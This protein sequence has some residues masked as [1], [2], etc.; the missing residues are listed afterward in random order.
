MTQQMA[1]EQFTP[2]ELPQDLAAEQALLGAL[3]VS[4][5]VY[6]KVSDKLTADMFFEPVHGRIYDAIEDCIKRGLTATPITLRAIFEGDPALAE[7]GGA[8]YLVRLMG[9]AATTIN[10]GDY[11][12]LIHDCF[13]RRQTVVTCEQ[14]I[15]EACDPRKVEQAARIL[16]DLEQKIFDLNSRTDAHRA[17]AD[18]AM[19][20]DD[21]AKII[22]AAKTNPGGAVGFSTGIKEWDRATGGLFGGDLY[23][24]GGRPGMGKSAL[25]L[26][27]A[28]NV[29]RAGRG[30]LFVSLEMPR[31]QLG[32]RLASMIGYSSSTPVPYSDARKGLFTAWQWQR[33][34]EA[35]KSAARLPL[36]IDDKPGRSLAAIKIGL[37][38]AVDKW[39]QEGIEPGLLVI[40]YLGL[41]AVADRYRG[42]KTYE[43]GEISKGLKEL[44]KEF[45]IPVLALAQLNRAVEQRESKH[46]QLS[47]LR[48]SGDIEQ[49]ADA[50]FFCYRAFYY[51]KQKEHP[52]P[53]VLADLER[54][55][56]LIIA[57]QRNGP[58]R[59]LDLFFDAPHG[60]WSDLYGG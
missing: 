20:S 59:T 3:F 9:G 57:K 28:R 27:I 29:A 60:L 33:F 7:V 12:K 41:V 47:D 5:E 2:P 26:T 6:E 23:I 21:V 53:T 1:N 13:L 11:A 55:G 39:A 32:L 54:Q 4:N 46:P 17:M 42:N 40:D 49:D 31:D 43:I 8:Q 44:A 56:Q 38:R 15:A 18:M 51:E 24:L 34:E 45:R 48:E 10:A 25:G 37:K 36:L 52:D 14:A 30:V 50:V 58:T 16:A 35:N 19:V 22:E